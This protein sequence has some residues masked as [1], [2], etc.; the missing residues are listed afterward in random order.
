MEELLKL[1]EQVFL[2][3]NGIHTP[4]LDPIMAIL[5]KTMVWLPLYFVLIFLLVKDYK[6]GSWLI[7]LGLIISILLTDQITSSLM[8]PFFER[9]RPSHEP[10]LAN[11]IH[12]VND[13]RGGMYGF[14]SSHAA[15]TFGVAIFVWL[16]LH[17]SYKLIFLIFV[18]ATIMS[19][20]R[21]YLGLHYPG[22]ILTGALIGITVGLSCFIAVDKIREKKIPPSTPQ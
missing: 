10:S 7:L 19:Y 13:E 12:L 6:K 9:L 4:W 17:K 22:D 14:A 2:W 15:N 18:W 3:L 5:T 11:A 21:I 16:A 8:K 20:S 1:D